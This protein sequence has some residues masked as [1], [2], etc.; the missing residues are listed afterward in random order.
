ME[1][2]LTWAAPIASALVI[3]VGQALVAVGQRKMNQRMDE[4][5]RKRDEA[6]NET[7]A[8]RKAEAEWRE[9]VEARL[10]EQAEALRMV[11][12]DKVEWSAW[13][14]EMVKRLDTQFDDHGEK[15]MSILK[16]QCTQMRSD[17][18]HKMHRYLD[19]LGCASTEEKDAFWA[20]YQEYCELCEQYGIEN[21]FVDELAKKV[22]ALP[23][24]QI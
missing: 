6:R 4:G 18:L 19:D 2:F 14:E 17:T 8:K 10:D 21:D 12:E 9:A 23:E 15:I 13:R 1:P 22:M 11:A 20:E 16:A 5:E 7:E 24:R 3:C